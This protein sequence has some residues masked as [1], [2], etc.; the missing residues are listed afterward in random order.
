MSLLIVPKLMAFA[1][2]LFSAAERRAYRGATRVLAGLLIETALA[3]LIAPA[4]MVFQSRA[5]TEILFG[6]DAG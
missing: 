1:T 6:R 4:M 5:V 3:A 2:L